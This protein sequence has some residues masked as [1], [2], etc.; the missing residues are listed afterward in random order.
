MI[1][2]KIIEAKKQEYE[3]KEFVKKWIGKGKISEIKIERTPVGEKIVVVTAKPGMVIGQRGSTIQ[4]MTEILK[5]KFKLENPQIEVSELMSPIFDAK[6]VADQIALSMERFGPLGF[7]L[8][9][10][11]KLEEIIRAGGLGAEIRLG[12][13]LP[14]ERARSWRF[15]FGY[16]KKTGGGAAIANRAQAQAFTRPGVVGIKVAIVPKDAR[17]PD[18]IEINKEA[19]ENELK[20]L[21]EVEEKKVKTEKN[22]K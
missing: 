6:T 7:K 4:E 22:E 21:I 13:K 8:I 19:I 5:K 17:I 9:V 11:K 18:K 14:S 3:I 15:A 20:K 2:K 12:G 10:Y 16:L 1:E